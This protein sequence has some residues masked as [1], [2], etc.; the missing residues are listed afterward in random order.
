MEKLYN[1]SFVCCTHIWLLHNV[2]NQHAVCDVSN[3]ELTCW[4][5]YFTLDNNINISNY[6]FY[7]EGKYT[8]KVA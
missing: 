4:L 6:K 2:T 8:K 7:N 1:N 5:T 3:L